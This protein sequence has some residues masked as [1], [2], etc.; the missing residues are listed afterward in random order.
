MDRS[1][2]FNFAVALTS[3]DNDRDS[4]LDPSIAE[5]VFHALEWGTNDSG[6]VFEREITLESKACTVS[7][8]GLTDEGS[9]F[10]PYARQAVKN[11]VSRY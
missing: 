2:H 8:L 4:I 6:E 11:D 10:L 7:D 1:K 5:F 9:Q 3:F